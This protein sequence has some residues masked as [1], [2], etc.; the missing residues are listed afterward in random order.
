[1]NKNSATAAGKQPG[2]AYTIVDLPDDHERHTLAVID[3]VVASADQHGSHPFFRIDTRSQLSRDGQHNIFLAR[4]ALP[5]RA[6]VVPAVSRINR[7]HDVPPGPVCLGRPLY[8][9]QSARPLQVDNQAVP[10]LTIGPRGE[11][12]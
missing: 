8:G 10:V 11:T 2:S 12:P 7:D 3:V 5:D 1:M 9:L 6:R 4:P